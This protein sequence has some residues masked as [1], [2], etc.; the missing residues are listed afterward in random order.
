[1]SLPTPSEVVDVLVK[2][3]RSRISQAKF[4]A[5]DKGATSRAASAARKLANPE[6]VRQTTERYHRSAKGQAAYRRSL[7]KRD[8]RRHQ[9]GILKMAM[10]CV[11]CP[12]GT[13]W[14]AVALQF[15]HVRGAKS[16]NICDG[17]TRPLAMLIAE[18]E[19]TEVRCANHHSMLT[20]SRR[21]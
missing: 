6:E 18:L 4:Q 1:V 12:A 2:R 14:P 7:Q 10:Q 20:D 9:L 17:V 19:K 5:S 21:T 13:I 15:D 11:D 3:E 8:A 16:F